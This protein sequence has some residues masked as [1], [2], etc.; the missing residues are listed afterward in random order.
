MP[1]PARGRY[2][3]H[4]LYADP[5]RGRQLLRRALTLREAQV[6]CRGPEAS[7]ETAARPMARRRT[8]VAGAWSLALEEVAR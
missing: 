7:S 4:R 2:C 8:Q 6:L 3:V 1:R 5:S